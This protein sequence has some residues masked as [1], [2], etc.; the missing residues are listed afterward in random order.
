[1]SDYDALKKQSESL[2]GTL[3][4]DDKNEPVQSAEQAS[5]QQERGGFEKS[6]EPTRYG[7]WEIAGRCI[8]F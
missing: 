6:K 1:M 5:S 7:D 3:K 4:S 8:D 2:P